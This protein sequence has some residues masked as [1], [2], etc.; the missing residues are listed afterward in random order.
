LEKREPNFPGKVSKDLPDFYPWW[1]EKE[2][3]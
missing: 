2:F 1:E 3:K